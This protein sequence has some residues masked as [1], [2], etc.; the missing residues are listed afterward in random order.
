MSEASGTRL[1]P[2]YPASII[3]SDV[4]VE[5]VVRHVRSMWQSDSCVNQ[6]S[7]TFLSCSDASSLADI[8]PN[9]WE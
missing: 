5:L 3:F 9:A 7:C 6:V 8:V 2:M 4:P 1:I